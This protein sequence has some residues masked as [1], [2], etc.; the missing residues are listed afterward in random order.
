MS[1][2]IKFMCSQPL[3][4]MGGS[5]VG[6]SYR[7]IRRDIRSGKTF[8][9]AIKREIQRQNEYCKIIQY[10]KDRFGQDVSMYYE[11]YY[12]PMQKYV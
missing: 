5:I 9:E 3:I 1:T 11:K 6:T 2:D 8:V 4:I 10:E 7:R 12:K